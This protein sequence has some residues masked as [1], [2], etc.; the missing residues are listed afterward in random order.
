MTL[1][2]R[3]IA[4]P[5]GPLRMVASSSALLGL[6]FREHRGA[7]PDERQAPA[8]HPILDQ[9]ERE[10]TEYFAGRRQTFS[11]PLNPGGTEFQRRVWD[12]LRAIPFGEHRSYLQLATTLGRP[13]AVR[14]VASANGRNPLSILVPC[15]RVIGSDGAL[16]GYA[17]GLPAKRW[18]LDHEARA[19]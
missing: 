10:L 1:V 18:L 12:E 2:Q 8:V 16:R 6:Y 5:V 14:A 11:V 19:A 9:V 15:H 4:S 7:P 3:T 17:G 13:R